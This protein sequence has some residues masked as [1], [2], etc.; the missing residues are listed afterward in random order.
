MGTV[1]DVTN[2]VMFLLSD[3][4]SFITGEI[5]RVSGGGHLR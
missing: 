3:E 5:L 1:N 2:A 4:S